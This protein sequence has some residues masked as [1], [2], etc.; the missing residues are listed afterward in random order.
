MS[1]SETLIAWPSVD[2]GVGVGVGVVGTGGETF[3]VQAERTTEDKI[4]LT[5][6]SVYLVI[7]LTLYS[8]FSK[9]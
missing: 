2:E 4:I 8:L 5:K 9:Y 1:R 3:G 7:Y 6:G